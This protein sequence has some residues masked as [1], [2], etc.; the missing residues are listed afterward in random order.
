[1][2]VGTDI[3]QDSKKM[4]GCSFSVSRKADPVVGRRKCGEKTE[5]ARARADAASA[6]IGGRGRSCVAHERS[7]VSEWVRATE[8]QAAMAPSTTDRSAASDAP[9]RAWIESPCNTVQ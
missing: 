9:S 3:A 7:V 2:R 8:S 5:P 4:L 1:M 6:T